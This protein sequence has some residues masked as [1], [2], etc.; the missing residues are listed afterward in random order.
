ML[1]LNGDM[2]TFNGKGMNILLYYVYIN[3]KTN[4]N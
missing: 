2:E 3:L 1:D 4:Y